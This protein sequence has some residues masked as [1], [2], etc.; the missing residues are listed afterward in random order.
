VETTNISNDLKIKVEEQP[1]GPILRIKG[2][3]GVG[4]GRTLDIELTRLR[5]RRPKLVVL[6]LSE[7]VMI[8]SLVMGPLIAAQ[9]NIV[10]MGGHFR[11]AAVQPKV[12]DCF[13]RAGLDSVFKIFGD[14]TSALAV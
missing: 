12:M 1:S 5:A 7:L 4:T 2:D 6:D 11:L 14:V 8:S 9:R 3:P 13:R 10:R